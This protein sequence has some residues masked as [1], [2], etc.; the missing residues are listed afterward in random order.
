M[1]VAGCSET[2]QPIYQTTRCQSPIH[3]NICTAV[4]AKAAPKHQTAQCITFHR[5]ANTGHHTD[6]A[7]QATQPRPQ[8]FLP[9]SAKSNCSCHRREGNRGNRGGDPLIHNFNTRWSRVFTRSPQ[10]SVCSSL[11]EACPYRE[12][13]RKSFNSPQ[14]R[15]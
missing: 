4:T 12:S 11:L 9:N 13:N 7:S 15:L 5:K 1:Q 10:Y 2:L 14:P 6:R 3:Y 8:L